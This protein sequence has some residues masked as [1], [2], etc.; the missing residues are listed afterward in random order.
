MLRPKNNRK[1]QQ[2]NYQ[3]FEGHFGNEK[4]RR[5]L[6]AP[7]VAEGDGSRSVA[8]RPHDPTSAWSASSGSGSEGQSHHSNR[9]LGLRLLCDLLPGVHVGLDKK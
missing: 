1:K 7:D 2:T 6:V 8:A 4:V 9:P 3:T 5:L